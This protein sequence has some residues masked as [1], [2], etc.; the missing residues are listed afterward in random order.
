[1]PGE[2]GGRRSI[3]RKQCADGARS[4]RFLLSLAGAGLLLV[5]LRGPVDRRERL[6]LGQQHLYNRRRPSLPV[7]I[8]DLNETSAFWALVF[9]RR[10]KKP[11]LRGL[12][13]FDSWGSE[14]GLE[15]GRERA[16]INERHGE[17]QTLTTGRRKATA[18]NKTEERR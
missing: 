12:A 11:K 7:G 9:L 10:R 3:D 14:L 13:T 15:A 1:M 5:V 4:H 6:V 8:G 18:S 2:F 16:T 17:V